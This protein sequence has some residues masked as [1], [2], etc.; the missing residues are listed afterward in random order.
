MFRIR[1]NLNDI[2]IQK[3]EIS[4][5]F[6]TFLYRLVFPEFRGLKKPRQNI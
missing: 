4:R 5:D 2:I 1:I 6:Y 3:M